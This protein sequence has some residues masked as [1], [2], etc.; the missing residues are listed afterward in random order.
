[1]LGSATVSR[2]EERIRQEVETN[3][4]VGASPSCETSSRVER[5]DA[6]EGE[7]TM[8]DPNTRTLSTGVALPLVGFGT[9]LIPDAEAA[10]AVRTAIELGYR[11]IDTAEFYANEHG[12]GEGLREALA[13]NELRR[14]DVFV[15]TKLFPGNAA[16]GRRRRPPRPPSPRSRRASRSSASRTSTST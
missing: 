2:S 1:M 16:W 5:L 3:G 9:Y 13:A 6:D 12:V 10:A 4:Q 7:T 15:T 14:E 11:H 8:T